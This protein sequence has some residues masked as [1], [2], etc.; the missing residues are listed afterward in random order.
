MAIFGKDRERGDRTRTSAFE[1]IASSGA[2]SVA[3]GEMYERE[4]VRVANDEGSG[5]SAFLGKGSRI[6]GKLSFEGPARIEGTVEGEI[7]AQD[8]LTIGESAVVNA[9]IVGNSVIIHGRV[10][11]DVTA[12]K[13]LEVRAPGRLLG[14]ITTP[15]LV[16]HEGVV[17]EGQCTMAGDTRAAE[18]DR[19]VMVFPQGDR[20]GDAGGAP[21]TAADAAK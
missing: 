5:S 7:Q 12:R 6:V 8:T 20:D 13:R 19:K 11:G 14:N 18:K 10:T 9:Q 17:F 21:R 3:E 16:I 2:G 15:S 1:G 4:K